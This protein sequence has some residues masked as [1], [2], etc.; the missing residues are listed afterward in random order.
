MS[1]FENHFRGLTRENNLLIWMRMIRSSLVNSN[2]TSN[3]DENVKG[4]VEGCASNLFEEDFSI[5]EIKDDVIV[6]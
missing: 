2:Q 6:F 4:N 3:F 5:D 1:D